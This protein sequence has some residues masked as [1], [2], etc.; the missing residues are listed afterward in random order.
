MEYKHR[1]FKSIEPWAKW[2]RVFKWLAIIQVVVTFSLPVVL[3]ELDTGVWLLSFA[4]FALWLSSY[5]L[6]RLAHHHNPDAKGLRGWVNGL[7][8]NIL[9]ITWVVVLLSIIL[10]FFKLVAFMWSA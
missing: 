9:F 7:W 1:I 2:Y 6:V 4:F 8:E 3:P 10:L 5:A